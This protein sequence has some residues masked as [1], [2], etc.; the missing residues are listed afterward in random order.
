MDY[1]RKKVVMRLD[2]DRS[3]EPQLQGLRP[4][5]GQ[6][7]N[8]KMRKE[9]CQKIRKFLV[10][11]SKNTGLTIGYILSQSISQREVSFCI[12]YVYL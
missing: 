2:K 4:F 7:K 10:Q 11:Q 3:I 5:Y 8:V 1:K 9:R 6:L 12:C